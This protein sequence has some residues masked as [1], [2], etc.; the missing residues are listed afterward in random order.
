MITF[1]VRFFSGCSYPPIYII[2]GPALYS[3][4]CKEGLS[5]SQDT[6]TLTLIIVFGNHQVK[7]E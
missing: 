5:P 6:D 3:M 1:S 2:D 7:V 4:T